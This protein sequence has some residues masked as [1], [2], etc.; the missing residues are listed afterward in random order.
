MTSKG[1]PVVSGPRWPGVRYFCTTRAGGIG[2]APH[3]TL[4][5]G[6]RAGD[7]AEAVAENRRRVR[8]MLP[9]DPLWLRQV[10][11]TRVVD[12]D[13]QFEDEPAADASVTA[14]PDRPLAIMV[15]DC[16]PVLIVEQDG[17][18]LGAAHAGWRGLSGGVLE[19][20]LEAMRRKCPD[21]AGW[22]AWIGP[23]I[24]PAA[25]EVGRDVVD[26]FA[27]D[28][29]DAAALFR[30][31][32]ER[33]GKWLADLPGLAALRLRRAGVDAVH[34]S[35]LCTVSDAEHF[36]SYR[37]DGETGRMALLAWLHAQ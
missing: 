24:G 9:A 30:P 31:R 14:A 3:D 27:V 34:Q 15:A 11:G 23:G 29:P 8:A 33:P 37:R 21:A 5:L 17:R 18:A 6:L 36:F 16:L 12:V 19:N 13:G 25:F 32:P 4:N 2:T 22:R 7:R 20:T 26:A 35:G 10:H 1:L 28:G